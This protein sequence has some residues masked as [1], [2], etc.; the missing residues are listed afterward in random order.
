VQVRRFGVA[1]GKIVIETLQPGPDDPMCCPS[2]YARRTF[3]LGAAGLTEVSSVLTARMAMAMINGSSWVLREPAPGSAEVTLVVK[4][5]SV[6]G[7]A[8]CNQYGA[9]V[10][11]KGARGEIGVSAIHATRMACAGDA[12]AMEARFL[13]ALEKVV[14]WRLEGN[15]LVLTTSDGG[16][17]VFKAAS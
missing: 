6:S 12:M 16:A 4:D 15:D 2:V 14:R 13:G 3:A 10:T 9:T 8:G 7:S 17:L 11:Q 1:D 5:S